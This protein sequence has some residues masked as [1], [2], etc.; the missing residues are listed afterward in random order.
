M[1]PSVHL[2]I[3]AVIGFSLGSINGDD[4][5]M[6]PTDG[7]Q[8]VPDEVF[9]R[10]NVWHSEWRNNFLPVLSNHTGDTVLMLVVLRRKEP[11]TI[12]ITERRGERE[13]GSPQNAPLLGYTLVYAVKSNGVVTKR[14]QQLQRQDIADMLQSTWKLIEGAGVGTQ[15]INSST[16]DNEIWYLLAVRTDDV[17]TIKTRLHA[18][19]GLNPPQNGVLQTLRNSLLRL[20]KK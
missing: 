13:F 8:R 11:E 20:L 6:K 18:A 1:S 4:A 17:G 16:D 3:L 19:Q 10:E 9:C 2:L 7:V 15:E 12:F 14:T 5:A